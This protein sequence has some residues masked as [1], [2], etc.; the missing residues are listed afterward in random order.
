MPA[1]LVRDSA[2]LTRCVFRLRR[3]PEIAFE[4]SD[5]GGGDRRLVDVFRVQFLGR[6]KKRI[7]RALAIRRHHDVAARGRGTAGGRLSV[8]TDPRGSNVMGEGAAQLVVLD[9]ADEGGATAE[10]RDT[11]D[12]VGCGT[13]EPPPP[14][15]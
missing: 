1:S 14:G 13:A 9:L 15:P 12:G 11:D 10:A 7:H 2:A 6:A 8:E 3:I 4:I 5:R